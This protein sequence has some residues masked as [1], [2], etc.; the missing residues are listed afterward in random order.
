MAAIPLVTHRA[1]DSIIAYRAGVAVTAG[2]FLTDVASL[3]KT[4]P[5]STHV[6]NNCNDRYRSTVGL[7]ASV[8]ARKVSLLPSAHTPQIIRQLKH[9]AAD[10]FCLTD[11]AHCDI[12]LPHFYYRDAAT[13]AESPWRIPQIDAEQLVAYVFTSGST[14]MPVPHKKTWGKLANCVTEGARRLGLA[15]G[16]SH[17]LLGTVPAQHMYG[18]E[19][20]VLTCL[21]SGNALCA[22]RP[23]Y[24]ADICAGIAL[25]PRPRVLVTTPIHLRTLLQADLALPP[26]DTILSATAPLARELALATE[27]R[28]G[29]PLLEIYGST[30]TGQI[31]SRRTVETQQWT[32]WPRVTLTVADGTAWIQGGHVEEPTAMGDVLEPTSE[33]NFTL[34]GRTGDLVNIAGKR[35]SLGHLNHH[36]NAI[37]GIIDGTFFV[38]EDARSVATG[39]TRLGAF[40]VAPGLDATW[41]LEQLRER[42]DPVFLP[43]PLLFVERLPRSATGKLPLEALRS[44]GADDPECVV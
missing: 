8:I 33:H 21:Q 19:S 9:F 43:R 16:R 27:S 39:V 12:D 37:P 6:L 32:L 4:L 7:A 28:F 36:L 35:G 20:T 13:N 42:I 11:D 26:I 44:L 29:A 30:E 31:A 10:A 1:R 5:A 17:A 40:V 3:A 2:R 23:F 14:G 41:V 22:E 34:H 24:P 18:L 15:D 25:L 38:R